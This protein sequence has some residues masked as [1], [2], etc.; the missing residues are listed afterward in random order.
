MKIFKEIIIFLISVTIIL[1][2]VILYVRQQNFSQSHIDISEA[3][4]MEK[5][6]FNQNRTREIILTNTEL[7]ESENNQ[8]VSYEDYNILTKKAPL[9]CQKGE[10]IWDILQKVGKEADVEFR[11]PSQSAFGEF[12]LTI[13]IEALSIN[14]IL[15][16]LLGDENYF[17]YNRENNIVVI[18]RK[19]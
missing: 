14:D 15:E 9:K 6:E 18:M 11:Y 8:T 10:K 2:A 19:G 16:I 13:D 12:D 4:S 3:Q 17:W 1:A 5:K 7:P